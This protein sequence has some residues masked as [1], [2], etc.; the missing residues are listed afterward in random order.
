MVM[1]AP[2]IDPPTRRTKAVVMSKKRAENK[3]TPLTHERDASFDDDSV[4]RDQAIEL[5]KME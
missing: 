4:S 1:L 5:L 2:E 3:I